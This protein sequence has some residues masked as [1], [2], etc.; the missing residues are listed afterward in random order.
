MHWTVGLSASAPD[1]S[2]AMTQLLRKSPNTG[3]KIAQECLRLM[4]S[5]LRVC[6]DWA[7]S[8]SQLRFLVTWALTDVEEAAASVAGFTLLRAIISRKLV[9]PEVYDVMGNVEDL[10]VKSQV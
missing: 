6:S 2:L 10:M 5:L 4:A 1:A 9:I 3:S 7:P 8:T